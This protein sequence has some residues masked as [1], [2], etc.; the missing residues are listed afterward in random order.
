MMPNELA[1]ETTQSHCSWSAGRPDN[2]P[3]STVKC[4][5]NFG[6]RVMMVR[7]QAFTSGSFGTGVVS[8]VRGEGATSMKCGSSDIVFA[9][10]PG[11]ADA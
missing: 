2:L 7:V 3:S 11:H 9:A 6:G 5:C 10:S 8:V 4:G 1:G